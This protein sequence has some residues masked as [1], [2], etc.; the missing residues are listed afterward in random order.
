MDSGHRQPMTRR[1]LLALIGA[2][3]GGSVMYQAMTSLGHAAQ[4]DYRPLALDGD[5]KGA[6]VVILGAGL[7]GM[8]AALELRQAGYTVRVLEY[9]ARAGG[10]SWTLRGGDRYTELG[11]FAQSCGFDKGLYFN[12][13]PWRIPFHHRAILDYCKRLKVPLE[14]FVQ[15]NYN[16]YLHAKDA[17]AGKPQRYRHIAADFSGGIAELLAKAANQGRL[18][19]AVS[20]EDKERL[21]EALKGWGALDANYAY[22]A[23]GASDRRGFD[24]DPGGGL[25]AVPVPSTPLAL[26]DIL[27]AR[28]W[29]GLVGGNSY[30]FLTTMFQPVGGMDMIAKAF[31]REVGGLIRYNSKVTAIR[32]DGSRVTVTYRDTKSG[33]APQRIEADW[34]LCT[35]PLSIL[36]QIEMN[37]GAPMA[38][39]IAGVPYMAAVK[40][41]LQMKRRFWEEDEAIYGGITTTDLPIRNIGYPCTDY[42][43]RGKGV[44]LGAYAIFNTYAYEFG[45]LPPAERI[46][47]TVEWGAM[48]HPQYKDEFDNGIAVAWQR[49]PATLGCF[50]NWSD[51]ARKKHYTDLCQIDGRI[52]LAGEHA[53]YLPAWQEGAILSA[54]D[55]VARL[56]RRVVAG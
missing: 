45:A 36:G 41:G 27:N 44:L 2:A 10:R 55:A 20:K 9:A 53:S 19:D 5:A 43:H 33:G 31:A 6:S 23:D 39:A 38:A 51:E 26:H 24:K 35:I 17:F 4:S 37:V 48:I 32:Q 11:G 1:D 12:P 21:L 40:V 52:A 16:A 8:T 30:D 50:A 29:Q 34:C 49:N 18:D 7:A 22:T 56:H 28:L 15:V 54:L 3:A 47:K 46:A 13:G 42:G 14:P 25:S